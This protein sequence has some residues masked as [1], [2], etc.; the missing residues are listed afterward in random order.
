MLPSSSIPT[1]LDDFV[2]LVSSQSKKV[3]SGTPQ[4]FVKWIEDVPVVVIPPED[5][6]HVA[7]SLADHALIGKFTE[8]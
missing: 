7:L 2:L 3:T 8:L 5:N 1:E 6:I 4:K